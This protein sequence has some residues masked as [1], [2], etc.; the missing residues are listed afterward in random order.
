[1]GRRARVLTAC[2]AASPLLTLFGYS[3]VHEAGHAVVALANG[4]H[5]DRFAIGP[6]AHVG[7]SGGS[8]SQGA[9]TLSHAA[10]ALLPAL[11]LVAALLVYRSTVRNDVYHVLYGVVATSTAASLLAWVAIPVVAMVGT[12]PPEDDVTRFLE[13]SGLPP[14][15]LAALSIL[16]LGC[17]VA[18][19]V[20]R[21]LPQACVGIVRDVAAERKASAKL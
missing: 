18:L 7:W 8:F 3:A 4:A 17:L 19:A 9:V 16:A 12:P 11:L 20:Q 21:G 1:M 2:L 13:S 5:I 14:L 10:G 6:G 15:A